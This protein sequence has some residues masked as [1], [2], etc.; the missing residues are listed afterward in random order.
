MQHAPSFLWCSTEPLCASLQWHLA[1]LW[2]L[3]GS[4]S[5]GSILQG[6]FFAL[7]APWS[8]WLAAWFFHTHGNKTCNAGSFRCIRGAGRSDRILLAPGKSRYGDEVSSGRVAAGGYVHTCAY[9]FLQ[10]N[11]S[12]LGFA[13]WA[14]GDARAMGS[15]RDGCVQRARVSFRCSI[16]A[17]AKPV[18]VFVLLQLRITPSLIVSQNDGKC[19]SHETPLQYISRSTRQQLLISL[20]KTLN[21]KPWAA[22]LLLLYLRNHTIL[23]LLQRFYN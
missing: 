4:A 11:V 18:L 7:L 19:P 6:A 8:M 9:W 23:F 22:E 12:S 13:S 2:S 5:A 10:G 14:A 3:P 15:D 1:V 17:N 20:S 16:A 21:V